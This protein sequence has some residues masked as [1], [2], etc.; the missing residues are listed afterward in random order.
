MDYDTIKLILSQYSNGN[1]KDEKFRQKLVDVLIYKVIVFDDKIYILY[2][3]SKD[4]NTKERYEDIIKLIEKST[5]AQNGSPQ[6]LPEKT[7][8]FK[9]VVFLFYLLFFKIWL[10]FDY[11]TI[12]KYIYISVKF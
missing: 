2:N 8:V 6:Q 5:A 7:Q 12:L 9:G 3:F 1:F 4:D 10:Y 11:H